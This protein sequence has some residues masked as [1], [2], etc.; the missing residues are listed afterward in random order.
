MSD[1]PHPP[2]SNRVQIWMPLYIGDYLRDTI[3][4]THTQHGAYLL[5]IFAYWSKGEALTNQELLAIT[6]KEFDRVSMFYVLENDR[7]HHKRVDIE[8]SKA[9]ANI[10]KMKALS[11][12]GVAKRR[13]LGQSSDEPHG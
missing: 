5:S 2:P 7:W 1:R 12:K 6:G 3:G 11:E 4:L 9:N 13:S 8:L 10:L